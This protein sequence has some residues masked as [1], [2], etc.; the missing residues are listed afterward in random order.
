MNQRNLCEPKNILSNLRFCL[1]E[2]ILSD[3][4]L[5]TQVYSKIM[6]YPWFHRTLSRSLATELVLKQGW[7][8][9]LVRLLAIPNVSILRANM[10][11]SVPCAPKW[12][13]HRRI[14]ADIQLPRQ[15]QTHSN[16]NKFRWTVS[17]RASLVPVHIRTAWTFPNTFHFVG[18]WQFEEYT[19]HGICYIRRKVCHTFTK[20]YHC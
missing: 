5:N 1:S 19:T 7:L 10:E 13:S 9:L 16:I 8:S 20:Q 17:C 15:S 4:V 18:F 3:E 6:D 14:C 11:W 12:D 2:S